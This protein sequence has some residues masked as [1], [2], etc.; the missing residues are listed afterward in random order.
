M[1]LPGDPSSSSLGGV[2]GGL[3][4]TAPPL[5]AKHVEGGWGVVPPSRPRLFALNVTQWSHTCVP[6]YLMLEN[7]QQFQAVQL[8]SDPGYVAGPKI[9]PNCCQV[10]INWVLP[11]AKVGHCFMYVTYNGTPALSV[12]AADNVF[13]QMKT[14]FN[15]VGGLA[16]FMNPGTNLNGVTLLDIRSNEGSEFHSSIVAAPGKSASS[17]LPSE[18]AIVVTLKTNV[19]G[20]SGRGRIYIPNW[21]TNALGANDLLTAAAATSLT[22]FVQTGILAGLNTLGQPCLALRDRAGYTS[23]TTGR[24]FPPRP[25]TTEVITQAIVRNNT[26]D[27]QRRRGLK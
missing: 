17:S 7:L 8:L 14:A 16:D 6:K 15:A 4:Q 18:N 23:P 27:T 2:W 20:Q 13:F 10:R 26:W 1:S 24:V 25:A 11:N 22:T 5:R 21:A 19:R 12:T 9:V 3:S